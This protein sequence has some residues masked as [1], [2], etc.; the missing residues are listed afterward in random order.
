M[1]EDL[2]L[3]GLR[4]SDHRLKRRYQRN[5]LSLNSVA[6]SDLAIPSTCFCLLQG[7]Y[8]LFSRDTRLHY[9]VLIDE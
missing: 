5:A 6:C 7:L 2:Q 4:F 8:I 3:R 9:V 1:P